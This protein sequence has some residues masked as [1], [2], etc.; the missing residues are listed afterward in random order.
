MDTSV[1]HC[2]I[3]VG[4]ATS[5]VNHEVCVI[6]TSLLR[7]HR[8]LC[9]LCSG[10]DIP[11]V[12]SLYREVSCLCSGIDIAIVHQCVCYASIVRHD[13]CVAV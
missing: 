6:Q 9:C 2:G 1:A 7:L 5:V 4:N 3:S 13:V 10:V 12:L 11:V 8:E